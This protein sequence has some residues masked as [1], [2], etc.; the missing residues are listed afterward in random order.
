MRVHPRPIL[1]ILAGAA[2]IVVMCLAGCSKA[3][4]TV[5]P[6]RPAIVSQPVRASDHAPT[7]FSGE[8]RARHESQLAFRVGGKIERRLVDVGARVDAGDVLVTLDP[9]DFRLQLA[10]AEAAVA[11]ATADTGLARSERDRYATLL[12]RKLISQS[13]FDAQDT[14][15]AAAEARLAQARAQLDVARNQVQ[16][17]RLVADR[18]GVLTSIQA[19]TGQVVAPG[20]VVAVLAEDG[21]REVVIA[22]PEAGVDR[23]PVG[24]AA[25]VALWSDPG[26][27]LNGT[28]REVAPDADSA[29]RTWR[30]RVTLQ[31]DD[32]SVNLGQTARVRFDTGRQ[33]GRPHWAL[34][35][36]ALHVK[37]AEPAV[38][39]LDP[40]T[41]AVGLRPVEVGAY[42]ED[43]VEVTGVSE[44]DWVVVAG[45]HKLA[46]GQVVR[47]I[48]RDNRPVGF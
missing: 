1:P 35:L 5:V 27:A 33:D 32:G 36:A 18:A 12:E 42:R 31:D 44:N 10:A 9:A 43:S 4:E 13:Q 40:A 11:S 48:D 24:T 2:L 8:I 22:L 45:V 20:Q 15:L 38:W 34:P 14:G 16:Y 19:E 41:R 47:P 6:E 46:E 37:D 23:Y 30:A 21:E 29:S 28:L 3:P 25:R 17:A 7:Y 39:V 26:R